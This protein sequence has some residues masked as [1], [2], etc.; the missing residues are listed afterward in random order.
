MVFSERDV[1]SVNLS[2][3]KDVFQVFDHLVI[4]VSLKKGKRLQPSCLKD[5]PLGMSWQMVESLANR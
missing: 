1:E 3:L 5:E 4:F 2:G